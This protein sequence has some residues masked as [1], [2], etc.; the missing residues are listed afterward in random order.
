MLSSI[1]PISSLLP[2]E[3]RQCCDGADG[4]DQLQG[5]VNWDYHWV[6]TVFGVLVLPVFSP[7]DGG[8]PC[9][10]AQV[11]AAPAALSLR[12]MRSGGCC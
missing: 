3:W 8:A 7:L 2:Q 9:L 11:G 1:T 6:F 4:V 12:S 5:L 10:K